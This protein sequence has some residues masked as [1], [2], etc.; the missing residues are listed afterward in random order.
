M[1]RI[2]TTC[3]AA[4]VD[5][6]GKV[7]M[8][9]DRRLSQSSGLYEA[10]PHPKVA[11]LNGVLM[12]GSGTWYIVEEI[13]SGF[14][15]PK[16]GKETVQQYFKTKFIE[17]ITDFLIK[18]KYIKEGE[19][20]LDEDVVGDGE[21]ASFLIAV[22]GSVAEMNVETKRIST[23]CLSFPATI[24]CGAQLALGSLLTER[25]GIS[26]AVRLLEAVKVAGKGNSGCDENVD[27]I[28]ED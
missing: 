25:P 4:M 8:A 26:T 13:L 5:E 17:A 3:I 22:D 14:L 6:T 9:G 11:K 1:K 10:G 19:L 24:G 27:I 7:W 23:V 28:Y 16:R 15:P 21:A 18:R 20:G 12:G 2:S